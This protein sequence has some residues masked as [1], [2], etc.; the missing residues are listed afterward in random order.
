[1][2]DDVYGAF[3]WWLRTH[4]F[5]WAQ[6]L[7]LLAAALLVFLTYYVGLHPNGSWVVVIAVVACVWTSLSVTVI[8]WLR[9]IMAGIFLE[10]ALLERHK[11]PAWQGVKV[12][13]WPG[14][15]AF[16]ILL[17]SLATLLLG[18]VGICIAYAVAYSAIQGVNSPGF[19]TALYFSFIA[20]S[21]VGFGDVFP[22]GAG[23]LF[24]IL[25]VLAGLM[26]AIMGIGSMITIFSRIVT[27]LAPGLGIDESDGKVVI[28]GV[29][30]ER[31]CGSSEAK[32]SGDGGS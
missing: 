32:N 27:G 5:Y 2:D 1:M 21:T 4:L 13:G 25:Q 11:V 10:S 20:S 28:P 6:R 16:K 9:M 24:A 12:V 19:P 31:E 30:I 7:S 29:F 3:D 26:Y 23:R 8:V 14:F 17:R 18:Y 15:S 22:V